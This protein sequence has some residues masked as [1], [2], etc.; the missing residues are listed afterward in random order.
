MA[1]G[2]HNTDTL[3][4]KIKIKVE[5]FKLIRFCNFVHGTFFMSR[6]EHI[7]HNSIH[8]KIGLKKDYAVMV[9][10]TSSRISGE[11]ISFQHKF[12][13]RVKFTQRGK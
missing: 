12:Y 3:K 13:L 1:N 7:K 11:F 2:R 5:R 9:S 4:M 8:G 6:C 10:H